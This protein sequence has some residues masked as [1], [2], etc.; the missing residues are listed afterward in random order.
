LIGVDVSIL[1][2]IAEKIPVDLTY[3]ELPWKRHL[4]YVKT[5]E[6]NI[7]MGSS[8]NKER[9]G[10]TYFTVPYRLEEIRLF[11]IKGKENEIKLNTLADVIDSK[12]ILGVERG[13]FYGDQYTYLSSLPN[14]KYHFN[15]VTDLSQNVHM[16]LKGNIDGLLADPV[17]MN[18]YIEIFNLQGKFSE[19]SLYIHKA[20]IYFMLSKA[21]MSAELVT[22]FNHAIATLK[23]SGEIKK[24]LN[25]SLY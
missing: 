25:N 4:M 14:F 17:A 7:A 9:E 10:Y 11:V 16:L 18:A 1:N 8:K 20:E 21:S 15:E 24:I 12:Y 19:H 22:Q 2:A 5:G 13:Y 6:V 23:T 3:L